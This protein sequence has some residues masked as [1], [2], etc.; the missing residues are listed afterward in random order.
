[1]VMRRAISWLISNADTLIALILAIIVSILS[2]AGA[3][4]TTLVANATVATLA[5]LAFIMLHDRRV[6]EETRTLVGQLDHKFDARNPVRIISG[7]EIS[8]AIT[9]ARRHTEQWFFKGSTATFVRVV[10]IPECIKEARRDGKEFRVRLEILDPTNLDACDSYVRLY[11]SL[12]ES[13]SSPEMSWTVKGTRIESYATILAACWHKQRYDPLTIEIGLSSAASTF[14]WEAASQYFIL[15]QRGP[16]FPAML[17]NR[18][19]AFYSLFVSE[20]NASFRQSHKL[21]ME[22][23]R[24][25]QLSDEPTVQEVRA[26]FVNLR[27]ELDD[28]SDEDVSEIITKALNDENPYKA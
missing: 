27:T 12:A 25:A 6:Q 14:R 3:V 22:L 13:P 24:D 2:L 1:M 23:A 11:Q 10:I 17:I 20:L 21:P 18:T 16:R 19:D 7:K 9:E 15:T 8:Y 5:V 26:L 4:S 28:I